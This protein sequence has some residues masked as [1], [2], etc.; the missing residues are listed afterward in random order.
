MSASRPTSAARFTLAGVMRCAWAKLAVTPGIVNQGHEWISAHFRKKDGG[1]FFH[2]TIGIAQRRS[3]HDYVAFSARLDS[4]VNMM[5]WTLSETVIIYVQAE[6]R[7]VD[8][9]LVRACKGPAEE[10][11]P[12]RLQRRVFRR[13]R[14]RWVQPSP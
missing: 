11:R 13:L 6:M 5:S 1:N 10:E 7:L 12:V 9:H 2:V 14:P 4:P 8:V 3:R